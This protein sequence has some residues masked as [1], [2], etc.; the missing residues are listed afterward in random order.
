[1]AGQRDFSSYFGGIGRALSSTNYRRY[2]Y[3]HVFSAHGVWIF[4]VT[5]QWLM[6]HLT[7]SFGWLGAV[8][9]AYLAP[10]FVLGP[11]AGA[12]ADR[13]GHRRTAMIAMVLGV[14]M[15]T[16]VG[17][18]TL[19]GLMTPI[20]LLTLTVVQ[21]I[22]MSFDFPSRQ[23]LIPQLLER[24]NLAAA[25]SMNGATYYTAS[26]TGPALGG[27]VLATGNAHFG[28][29]GGA[30]V[31]Y[32]A[33]AVGMACLLTALIRV[34]IVNP[35]PSRR[36][37]GAIIP[38]LA[39]DIRAG[40]AYIMASRHLKLILALA[41]TAAM[42]LRPFY[43]LMAG[44]SETVFHLDEQGLGN[45][46]ASAGVGAL[47]GAVLLSIRGRT[48]GTTRILL[49][50]AVGASVSLL[51]F[52]SNSVVAVAFV[53][54]F[55]AGAF[56]GNVGTCGTTLV[57]NVVEDEYRARVISV[58]LAASVGGPAFGTLAIGSLAEF[59]GLQVAM[60]VAAA[61]VLLVLLLISGKFLA[62]AA[63]IEAD[64]EPAELKT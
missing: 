37:E 57:Q 32:F 54:C 17:V 27:F 41:V 30:A 58:N 59:T 9:F 53:A 49:L 61:L 43:N 39:A 21:G 48:Q 26:F 38:T 18:L 4:H 52:V 10:L 13:Y 55:F 1:M 16:A 42:M 40:I 29:P 47:I 33:S 6:F 46:L 34:Q 25:I 28:E 45:M 12:V 19:A 8:G 51:V 15:S 3:G 60:G 62:N 31:A 14:S 36:R 63:G 50:C 22:F 24:K 44:F 35:M 56:I 2:W 20:L 7:H 64:P 5:A 23:A 11:V